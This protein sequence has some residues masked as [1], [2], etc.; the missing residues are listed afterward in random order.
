IDLDPENV[1]AHH[2]YAYSLVLQTRYDEALD[3]IKIALTLDPF[4]LITNRTLGD[5]YFHMRE[6][7]K[8][9]EQLLKTL[10]MD[11][12]FNFTHAYLGLVY[13]MKSQCEDALD[14]IQ[15]ESVFGQGTGDIA[16]AWKGYAHAYC[17]NKEEALIILN[18]LI[19]SS[20]NRYIPPSF[21]TWILFAQGENEQGFMW[22]EKAFNER[23][24]YLTEIKSSHFYD[25]IRSDPRY[26]DLLQRM[27]LDQ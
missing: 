22:L 18:N 25:G 27:N 26:T 24:P 7:N 11:S 23:D 8:A 3:E 1:T 10:E 9:E 17:G 16:L 2:L 6:Y 19:E 12:A 5:F 13:L 21:F 20:K 14:E 15:K 4:N